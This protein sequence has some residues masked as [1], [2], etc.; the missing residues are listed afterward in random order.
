MSD[1]E[2]HK[3][4]TLIQ[5][6]NELRRQLAS[7]PTGPL[8]ASVALLAEEQRRQTEKLSWPGGSIDTWLSSL[9]LN[10]GYEFFK[11]RANAVT[12]LG[13]GADGELAAYQMTDEAAMF[14]ANK[15]LG[16][17]WLRMALEKISTKYVFNKR[18]PLNR[19]EVNT[20]Y[21]EITK[22]VAAS[23]L[24]QS[25]ASLS[26][27]SLS[28]TF[29][30]DLS[31]RKQRHLSKWVCVSHT[32]DLIR[33]SKWMFEVTLR[34]Q[35]DTG[36]IP[37]DLDK[38]VFFTIRITEENYADELL[39]LRYMGLNIPTVHPTTDWKDLVTHALRLLA[40]PDPIYSGL[41][42]KYNPHLSENG[43]IVYISVVTRV[44]AEDIDNQ[45]IQQLLAD[46]TKPKP[47][48]DAPIPF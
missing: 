11:N 25:D 2:I 41:T 23:T 27:T 19:S 45:H 14:L 37:T 34:L 38:T 29:V 47:I 48:K 42:R 36:D 9:S 7:G 35:H 13:K 3:D 22:L 30:K 44:E 33:L 31:A 39:A 16:E 17:A 12:K 24:H 1:S 46:W 26:K 28:R 32:L 15:N 5:L 20:I 6:E 40:Q 43:K 10:K 4:V 18:N 8:K 21:L